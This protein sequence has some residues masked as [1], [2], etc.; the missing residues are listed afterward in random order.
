MIHKPDHNVSS[1][2]EGKENTVFKR[3]ARYKKG[4]LTALTLAIALPIGIIGLQHAKKGSKNQDSMNQTAEVTNFSWRRLRI[5]SDGDKEDEESVDKDQVSLTK[6]VSDI[7]D[8]LEPSG[9]QFQQ[10]ERVLVV[11]MQELNEVV[12]AL[13]TSFKQEHFLKDEKS[14]LRTGIHK[15]SRNVERALGKCGRGLENILNQDGSPTIDEFNNNIVEAVK[16]IKEIHKQLDLFTKANKEFTNTKPQ[17]ENSE[18]VALAS[19]SLFEKWDIVQ[20]AESN[21]LMELQYQLGLNASERKKLPASYREFLDLMQSNP[22]YRK[23]HAMDFRNFCSDFWKVELQPQYMVH[24]N[25]K[26]LTSAYCLLT[27]TT[28]AKAAWEVIQLAAGDSCATL[29]QT[30]D[31]SVDWDE[32]HTHMIITSKEEETVS[33]PLHH[34]EGKQEEI[35]QNVPLT[36][37]NPKQLKQWSKQY[38]GDVELMDNAIGKIS[39][40]TIGVNNIPPDSLRILMDSFDDSVTFNLIKDRKQN[41]KDI[42]KTVSNTRAGIRSAIGDRVHIAN[43]KNASQWVRDFFLQGRDPKTQ[44]PIVLLPNETNRIHTK[45]ITTD[46]FGSRDSDPTTKIIPFMID[47]GD[48]RTVGPYLFVGESYIE[49]ALMRYN[50]SFTFPNG[51][52]VTKTSRYEKD[53]GIISDFLFEL[54]KQEETNPDEEWKDKK[55]RVRAAVHTES[56]YQ[57]KDEQISTETITK[58]Q[59]VN[60]LT[61]EMKS[62]FGREVFVVGHGDEAEQAIFHLDMFTTYLPNADGKPTVVIGD[63]KR[64]R[65][66]LSSLTPQQ[67]DVLE[68]QNMIQNVDPHSFKKI[69]E[70]E[71]KM[72]AEEPDFPVN[73]YGKNIRDNRHIIHDI[74]QGTQGYIEDLKTGKKYQKLEQELDAAAKWFIDRGFPVERSPIEIEFNTRREVLVPNE[75]DVSIPRH[76][77]DTAWATSNNALVEV[78]V[79]DD[80]KLHKIVRIPTFNRDVISND[81]IAMYNRLGY[82]VIPIPGLKNV[83]QSKGVLNCLT[84][85]YRTPFGQ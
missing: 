36:T 31:I 84:S 21:P 30:R 53:N 26:L 65:E 56:F 76:R 85:E 33:V 82:T 59:A 48:M 9:E 2:D 40:L 18:A 64:T 72:L 20:F 11:S 13:Q 78:Y 32:Q 50:H 42:Q 8:H 81:I 22:A 75:D 16:R 10:T 52:T 63:V 49:N 58:E 77:I 14:D 19:T 44:K 1:L 41:T 73:L 29:L 46:D 6:N 34:F 38:K 4:V 47:G 51:K 25:T 66:L 70:K 23:K 62:Y 12:D 28:D 39:D 83:S 15:C 24:F 5:R 27:K 74:D 79:D 80:G 71:E 68:K 43:P 37:L 54:K 57:I 17:L 45:Q 69:R 35:E 7:Q 67:M 61:K 55:D 3:I 60:L